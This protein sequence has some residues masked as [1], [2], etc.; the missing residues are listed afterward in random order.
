VVIA[1][2]DLGALGLKLSQV[3]E[4]QFFVNNLP[5]AETKRRK[6]LFKKISAQ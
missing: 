6:G 1:P 4:S 2:P 5:L 3:F